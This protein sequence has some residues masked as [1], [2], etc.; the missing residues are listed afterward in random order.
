[1]N[2]TVKPAVYRTKN[3][4]LHF[5]LAE[6][7][8]L[9]DAPRLIMIEG[10]NGVGKTTFLERVF[11]KRFKKP[12]AYI[13]ADVSTLAPALAAHIAVRTFLGDNLI[14]SAPKDLK[15]ETRRSYALIAQPEVRV[16]V[17]DDYAGDYGQI[18]DWVTHDGKNLSVLAIG[19]HIS[20][21]VPVDKFKGYSIQHLEISRN[22]EVSSIR[23]AA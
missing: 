8:T 22:E 4:D 17:L 16:V 18:A 7:I 10:G 14:S 11:L 2:F 6:A 20:S 19:N 21:R 5:H 3:P 12:V 9:S 1:M 15:I 23:R 13:S